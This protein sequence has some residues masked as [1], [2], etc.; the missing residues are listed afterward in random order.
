MV[1]LQL[2][3][4]NEHTSTFIVFWKKMLEQNIHLQLTYTEF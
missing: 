4:G 3:E 2:K 1:L